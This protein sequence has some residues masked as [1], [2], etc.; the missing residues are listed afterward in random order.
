MLRQGEDAFVLVAD[1]SSFPQVDLERHFVRDVPQFQK[2]DVGLH[3]ARLEFLEQFDTLSQRWHRLFETWTE[4][5]FTRAAAFQKSFIDQASN[6]ELPDDEKWVILNALRC[7]VT[8]RDIDELALN[9]DKFDESYPI[10]TTLAESGFQ[11]G[12]GG[13][14]AR[15]RIDVLHFSYAELDSRYKETRIDPSATLSKLLPTTFSAAQSLLL[16]GR[17]KDWSAIFYVLL[18]LFHVE[19]DL[20]SCGDLTTAFESAQVVVKEALHDLVRSFLFCCG[21]PGQGLHP[22][23]EHFDEEWYK[24]MVGADADPIYAEHYAW[25]HERWME[26][27]MSQP[28][29]EAY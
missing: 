11:S 20:Q 10:A 24:L 6:A 1:Y 8:L 13:H 3:T 2:P 18:I 21:G 15:P 23:L 14:R 29:E 25:H 16:R 22:F 9:M 26:N 28:H 4:D 19:G 17:P 27:G 12:V 5:T 7:L